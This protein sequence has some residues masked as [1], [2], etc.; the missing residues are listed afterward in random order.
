[1][2]KVSHDVAR[3]IENGRGHYSHNSNVLAFVIH[4][5]EDDLTISEVSDIMKAVYDGYKSDSIED[6]EDVNEEGCEDTRK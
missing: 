3:F 6:K 1:M 4:A 2:I 5:I